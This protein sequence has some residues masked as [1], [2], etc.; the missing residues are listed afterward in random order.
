[1]YIVVAIREVLG[2]P[3]VSPGRGWHVH[4]TSV[5]VGI[6]H[7]VPRIRGVS[8]VALCGADIEGWPVFPDK[9]F[10]PGHGASCQRC[11]QLV[12]EAVRHR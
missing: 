10:Q 7:A 1:M 5:P 8:T 9:E 6:R 3:M 11:A 4:Q 2:P 12:S